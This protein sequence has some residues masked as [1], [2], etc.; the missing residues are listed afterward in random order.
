MSLFHDHEIREQQRIRRALLTNGYSPLAQNGKRPYWKGWSSLPITPEV[1]DRWEG[2]TEFR[3]TGL[4]CDN[5]LIAIDIDINDKAMARRAVEVLAEVAPHIEGEFEDEAGPYRD[6]LSPERS[7]RGDKICLLFRRDPKDTDKRPI[8]VLRSTGH[9]RPGE[10]PTNA[11]LDAHRIEVFGSS[12]QQIG[13]FGPHSFN[14]DG[15]VAVEYRWPYGSPLDT[16]LIDLPV[17]T[18][19]QVKDFIVKMNAELIAAGWP[20]IER[21]KTMTDGYDGPQYILTDDMTFDCRDG[22]TRTLQELYTYAL[23]TDPEPRCSAAWYEGPQAKDRNRTKVNL[24]GPAD[25]RKL[26]LIV[27]NV[28]KFRPVVD[29]PVPVSEKTAELAVKWEEKRPDI[30]LDDLPEEAEQAFKDAYYEMVH[31]WAYDLLDTKTPVTHLYK[32]VKLS[33]K[34]AE[35]MFP[36]VT[37]H[38]PGPKGG[39][40]T[41]YTPY[42]KWMNSRHRLTVEGR[43]FRPDLPRGIVE[44]EGRKCVNSY[45]PPRHLDTHGPDPALAALFLR[46]LEHLIPQKE[47]REWFLDRL[48]H[49]VQHPMIPGVATLFYSPTFGTGRDTLFKIIAGVFGE[50]NAIPVADHQLR[51]DDKFT[52]W[53]S[54]KLVGTISEILQSGND[55][56]GAIAKRHKDY[57]RLKQLFEPSGRNGQ[58]ENKG[59]DPRVDKVCVSFFLATNHENALS[60]PEH[61][62]RIVVIDGTRERL[63]G[64]SLRAEL[65]AQFTAGGAEIT[66]AFAAAVWHLLQARDVSA[67]DPIHAPDWGA[68]VAMIEA[69]KTPLDTL[70]ENMLN[71]WPTDWVEL[72]TFIERFTDRAVRQKLT[73]AG[74]LSATASNILGR[75]WPH[76]STCYLKHSRKIT[77]YGRTEEEMLRLVKLSTEDREAELTLQQQL[78]HQPSAEL[79]AARLGLVEVKTA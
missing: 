59:V 34:N 33:T 44:V 47:A 31:E 11:D 49:K 23:Q 55:G 68:K 5:G 52:G 7:G 3:T 4:R 18:Y 78:V 69:N 67:F 8:S 41:V 16:P 53:M 17:L 62:R 71:D 20:R 10:D 9:V 38:E 19:A 61:D 40:G 79:R 27:F 15:S 51:G 21:S 25:D 48:A 1:I 77:V 22:V 60:F 56:A 54:N 2:V 43:V 72:N 37:H 28:G 32:G 29:K 57:E 26:E 66:P 14:P 45:T 65:Y 75:L 24:I 6:I 50:H 76:K 58:I 73:T 63:A 36:G 70:A 42:R 46:F 39:K 35:A 30:S 74:S 13:A 64:K 12:G